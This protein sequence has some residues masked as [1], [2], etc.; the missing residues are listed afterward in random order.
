MFHHVKKTVNS[1]FLYFTSIFIVIILFGC[2][3]PSSN[4][5]CTSGSLVTIPSKP[6]DWH[7]EIFTPTNIEV[8]KGDILSFTASGTW[9]LGLGP[10]GS[11]G[12]DDW[13]ECTISEPSG[14]G[15][16]GPVGALI[17][18][19]GNQGS[20]F[21]IGA[22]NIVTADADGILYLGSN[23]NMGPCNNVDR[24]SCYEDNRGTMNV[25]IE[26]K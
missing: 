10:V 26:I 8:K 2:A 25:C 21:L 13:C 19:I 9:N 12:K 3:A 11:D 17:G 23:E 6:D 14:E 24:G 5:A 20:P 7:S 16:R 18:R 4:L 22:Q 15:F 1:Y